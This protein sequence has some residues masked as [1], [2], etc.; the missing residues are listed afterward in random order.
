MYY[1][2]YLFVYVYRWWS[3]SNYS[4]YYCVFAHCLFR[5]KA[6][7]YFLPLPPSLSLSLPFSTLYIINI[8]L[9]FLCSRTRMKTKK[10]KP[11]D[12]PSIPLHSV[13]I[14]SPSKRQISRPKRFHDFEDMGLSSYGSKRS[15]KND[16]TVTLSATQGW[17]STMLDSL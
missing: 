5:A 17:W 12:P 2:V 6:F 16:V 3:A 10:A 11:K 13:P 4:T 1:G 9:K 8:L 14:M 7:F 15:R